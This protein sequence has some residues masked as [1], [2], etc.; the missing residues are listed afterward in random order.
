MIGLWFV[1]VVLLVWIVV[2]W[3]L[4]KRALHSKAFQRNKFASH[5]AFQSTLL[6]LHLYIAPKYISHSTSKSIC[7]RNIHNIMESKIDNNASNNA[8]FGKDQF[9]WTIPLISL[10]IPANE[11]K[12]YMIQFKNF[13]FKKSKMKSIYNVTNE[14]SLRH[15]LLNEKVFFC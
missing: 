13:M 14:P 2:I 4:F 3:M 5:S 1:L 11:C 6:F 7:N 12:N 15:F 8:L 10:K 9:K